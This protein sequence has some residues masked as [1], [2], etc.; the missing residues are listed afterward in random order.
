M[1]VNKEK[2]EAF[3]DNVVLKIEKWPSS[4]TGSKLIVPS[5]IE[6]YDNGRELYLGKVVS[7]SN[8]SIEK[9]QYVAIDIYYG[10]HLPSEARAE[11]LKIVPF[12]GI[13]LI[14]TKEFKV[15]SDVVKMTPNKDRVLLKLKKKETITAGGIHIPDEVLAQDPTAQDVRFAEV[16]KS[17]VPEVKKGETVII[18]SFVGKDIYLNEDKELYIVCYAQD[19]LAKIK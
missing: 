6:G 2:I 18:E 9:D 12:T 5:G 15:M 8:N 14:G 16:V 3:N 17:A 4:F 7:T 11:K 10:S 13:V 19:I 1:Y